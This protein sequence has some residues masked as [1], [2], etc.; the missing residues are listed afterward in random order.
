VQKFDS[1]VQVNVPL[2]VLLRCNI[3]IFDLARTN[4]EEVVIGGKLFTV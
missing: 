1:F 2:I 4:T 3:I